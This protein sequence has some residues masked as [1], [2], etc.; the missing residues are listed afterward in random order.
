R[1]GTLRG[2]VRRAVYLG[3]QVEYEVEVGGTLL[4]AIGRSPLEE[5]IFRE[6]QDVGVTIGF[7]VAHLLVLGGG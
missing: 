2:A 5:G 7:G 1:E 6:G 4:Q 3:S